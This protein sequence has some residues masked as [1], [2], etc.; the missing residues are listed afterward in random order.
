MPDIEH[1]NYLL[2]LKVSG[3]DAKT[4]DSKAQEI[5]DQYMK[6]FGGQ[7]ALTIETLKLDAI[8]SAGTT[9]SVTE[10]GA[11]NF[12]IRYYGPT[13]SVASLQKMLQDAATTVGATIT[14]ITHT[15]SDITGRY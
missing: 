6:Q 15:A 14:T 7:G 5:H 9:P 3:T 12:A 10:A 1:G 11:F 13:N 4:I 2:L 8:V